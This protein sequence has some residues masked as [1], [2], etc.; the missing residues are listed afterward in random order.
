[1]NE[2]LNFNGKKSIYSNEYVDKQMI[3]DLTK[4]NEELNLRLKSMVEMSKQDKISM[5]EEIENQVQIARKTMSLSNQVNDE[6][7]RT[8][9]T[10]LKSSFKEKLNERNDLIKKYLQ[11]NELLNEKIKI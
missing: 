3:K 4:Q 2:N 11:E 9:L 5:R 6:S 1:M 7:W 8:H 10:N